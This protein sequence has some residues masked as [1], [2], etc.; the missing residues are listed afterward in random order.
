MALKKPHDSLEQIENAWSKIV[1]LP[2][3][4]IIP[5]VKWYKGEKEGDEH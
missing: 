2:F 3:A 5:I 4:F 1:K